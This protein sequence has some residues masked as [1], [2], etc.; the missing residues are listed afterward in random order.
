VNHTLAGTR[1][2]IIAATAV[3]ASVLAIAPVGVNPVRAATAACGSS[4][5][6]GIVALADLIRVDLGDERL[7]IVG[8]GVR[9]IGRVENPRMLTAFNAD[10]PG[11]IAEYDLPDR[12]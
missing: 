5:T 10:D 1:G 7:G 12:G 2:R 4:G 11:T 8:S 6:P 9:P 3:L